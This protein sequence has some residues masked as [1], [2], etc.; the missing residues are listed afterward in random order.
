MWF[1]KL[2]QLLALPKKWIQSIIISQKKNENKELTV[3]PSV[4]KIIKVLSNAKGNEDDYSAME[5]ILSLQAHGW[6]ISNNEQHDAYEFY[7]LLIA[8]LNEEIDKLFVNS[9]D[10]VLKIRKQN[11]LPRANSSIINRVSRTLPS[12]DTT[13]RPND[14][15]RGSFANRMICDNCGYRSAIKFQKFGSLILNIEHA[16]IKHGCTMES[17][18][19]RLIKLERVEDVACQKCS[20]QTCSIKKIKTNIKRLFLRQTTISKLPQCLCIELQRTYYAND[21]STR[22]NQSFVRFPEFFDVTPYRYY[23]KDRKMQTSQSHTSRRPLLRGGSSEQKQK[24]SCSLSVGATNSCSTANWYKLISVIL[25]FGDAY[26][27]H[28]TVFRR[29]PGNPE[30]WVYIS[31][32]EVKYVS[33]ETVMNSYAYMLFYEKLDL[34]TLDTKVTL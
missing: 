11:H 27:G 6:M 1:F 10:D 8:T 34:H 14:P 25:H 16:T 18:F 32:Q 20:E 19:D 23:P 9:K 31:D 29:S 24:M 2:Y 22:K 3:A 15:F 33:K 12:L 28:F 7:Q 4:E 30:R 13:H 21:G 17:C 26:N 5:V